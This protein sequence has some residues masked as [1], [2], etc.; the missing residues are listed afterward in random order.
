M[1][2]TV[3]S[4]DTRTGQQITDPSVLAMS[5]CLA[6]LF[7]AT[8]LSETLATTNQTDA[9]GPLTFL[10]QVLG[11][12]GGSLRKDLQVLAKRLGVELIPVPVVAEGEAH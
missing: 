12:Q 11:E 3:A 10:V 9:L 7:A 2:M 6:I 5:R 4:I 1:A 8:D